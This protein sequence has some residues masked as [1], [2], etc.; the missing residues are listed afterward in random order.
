MNAIYISI[1]QKQIKR[2][3][4]AHY[5]HMPDKSLNH[6]DANTTKNSRSCSPCLLLAVD[7]VNTKTIRKTQNLMIYHT[8]T[9]GHR[10]LNKT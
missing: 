7:L 4:R 1:V 3:L 8:S 10:S 6:S 9:N 5:T 2:S